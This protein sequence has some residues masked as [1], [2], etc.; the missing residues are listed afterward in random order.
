MAFALSIGI[1]LVLI[2]VW[3]IIDFQ[4]GRKN[5]LKKVSKKEFPKRHSDMTLYTNGS[6]LFNDLFQ[7]LR[8]ADHHIHSLFYIVQD[9]HISKEFFSILI[10]KARKGVEVR[11]LLDRV[12]SKNVKKQQIQ[13]LKDNNI[14]VYYCHLPTFPYFFYSLN[15]RNHRKITVVDGTIGYIGGFNIGKEYLGQDPELGVWRDYHLK[16]LGE[17]VQDLQSQFLQDWLEESRVDLTTAP[18][19]FPP[20]TKG[21]SLHQIVPTNGAFLSDTFLMLLKRAQKSVMICTPYFIPSEK[22]LDELLYTLSKGI[23]VTILVP[24]KE[25]HPLVRDAAFPY[26]PALIEAGAEIY[27]FYQGF[28]H[29]K[30]IVIDDKVCDIGTA[31]FDK[32]SLFLN[33]EIN[34]LIF[35]TNFIKQTTSEIMEDIHNSEKLTMEFIQ[36]RS[37]LEKG[38]EQLTKIISPLL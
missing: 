20:L 11:L 10:D 3:L 8:N 13:E 34:C 6:A 12:G 27:R 14:E 18:Q 21:K 32:R 19:Y 37:L 36:N 38:K 22:L 17:G 9:D 23:K 15:Q 31:N 33:H 35:D 25:D 16:M 28:Y 29:A 5:H 24:V 7:D 4:L 30:V 1:L 26:Y 2:V